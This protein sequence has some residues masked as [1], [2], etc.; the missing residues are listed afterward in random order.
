MNLEELWLGK[1]KITKIEVHEMKCA[2]SPGVADEIKGLSNLKKLKIL[3]L[4][5]NRIV[6]LEGLEGL[7]SLEQLYLSHNGVKK[8]E[9]LEKIVSPFPLTVNYMGMINH[10]RQLNLTTLDVGNNFV[11]VLEHV[12]HLH[13]LTEL[14]VCFVSAYERISIHVISLYR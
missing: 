14:W 13:N 4:Q 12:S 9:G 6:K 5:S 1:N 8:L 7:E 2:V 10:I 3:A 11:E